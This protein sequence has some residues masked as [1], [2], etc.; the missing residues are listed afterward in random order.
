MHC[1]ETMIF[2]RDHVCAEEVRYRKYEVVL[3]I[4]SIEK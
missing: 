1:L 4:P 2:N 3:D